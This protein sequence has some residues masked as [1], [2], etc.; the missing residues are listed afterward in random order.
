MQLLD[1]FFQTS[2]IFFGKEKIFATF[3]LSILF[4]VNF[5]FAQE[6]KKNATAGFVFLNIPTNAR[7]AALGEASIALDNLNSAG[8]FV[9]SAILGFAQTQ[10]SFTASYSPWIAEIKNYS[11][12]YSFASDFGVLAAGFILFDY[13]SMPRTT[14]GAGQKVYDVV[15]SFNANSLSLNFSYSRRLTDRFSFGAGLKFVQETIDIYK[16]NNILFDGGVLYYTG[17]G[18]LRIAATIQ[19]FGTNAKFINDEFKMPAML[20]LGAA[21]EVFE[22]FSSDYRIT[23]STEALH[24]SDGDERINFGSEVSWKNI[25]SL[26]AGYKFFYDEESYSFGVGINPRFEMPATID[27]AFADYGRLGSIL[28][29]TINLGLN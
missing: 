29:F 14:V 28:R 10:H 7:T 9:N 12:A 17:L 24:P 13:G 1:K 2:K 21:V 27:F 15:G 16:A 3:F 8:L 23:L 6:F 11:A 4:L 18:S 5:S 20:R 26:R 22:N 19:N 25:I